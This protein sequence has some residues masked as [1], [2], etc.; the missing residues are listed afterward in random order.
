MR[1]KLLDDIESRQLTRPFIMKLRIVLHR[2]DQYN[3]FDH[4][5]S[6]LHATDEDIVQAYN[7]T[8]EEYA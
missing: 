5:W 8:L 2:R 3:M 6:F 4:A 1:I 7:A